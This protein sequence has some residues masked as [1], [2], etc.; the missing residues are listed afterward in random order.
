MGRKG[1]KASFLFPVEI[2]Y[3]PLEETNENYVETDKYITNINDKQNHTGIRHNI[4]DD[5]EECREYRRFKIILICLFIFLIL[6]CT[7][8]A[9][10]LIYKLVY[11][12]KPDDETNINK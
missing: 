7:V 4:H 1:R 2:C 8:V 5:C 12:M 11:K 6:C 3:I 10:I 9:G